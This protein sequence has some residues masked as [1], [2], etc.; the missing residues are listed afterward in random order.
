[1]ARLTVLSD[2]DFT[3]FKALDGPKWM[4]KRQYRTRQRPSYYAALDRHVDML[5]GFGFDNPLDGETLRQLLAVV[6]SKDRTFGP[7]FRDQ[8]AQDLEAEDGWKRLWSVCA[9]RVVEKYLEQREEP[10]PEGPGFF[11]PD[12]LV[13]SISQLIELSVSAGELSAEEGK[14]AGEDFLVPPGNPELVEDA[15]A[16][17]EELLATD[18]NF[19]AAAEGDAGR[20]IAEAERELE[21]SKSA[22]LR[23]RM[24]ELRSIAEAE[25][26][27]LLREKE[28]LAAAIVRKYKASRSEIAELVLDKLGDNP[29]TGHSTHLLPLAED[30][31]LETVRVRLDQLKGHYL[32]LEVAHWLVFTS[33]ASDGG[34][35][36]F[37]GELRYYDVAAQREGGAAEI[38]ARQRRAAVEVR[39]QKGIQWAEVDGR[40]LTEIRRMRS[41]FGRALDVQTQPAIPVIL[42]SLEG[43]AATLDRHTLLVLRI[44]ET[45]LRDEFIDYASFTAAEFAKPKVEGSEAD[46]MR[47]TVRQVKLSGQH[48]L[49][50]TDA[51]RLIANEGQRMAT[52]EFKA[53]FRQDLKGPTH[54]SSVKLSLAPDQATVM[55]SYGGDSKMSRR[56]HDEIVKRLRVALDRGVEEPAELDGIVKQIVDRARETGEVETVDILA[57]ADGGQIEAISDDEE[58]PQPATVDGDGAAPEGTVEPVKVDSGQS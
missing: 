10:A 36:R 32:R 13:S 2:A 51:C 43:D 44:L 50:S 27:P 57:P 17:L 45:G 12:A 48:I 46:P 55:T 49:S 22:L 21:I 16:A 58:V 54:L 34:K 39:L 52:V 1:M 9:G 5:A 29:E 24:R 6:V 35:A 47:P 19:A 14:T 26:L 28:A 53:R 42:P 8:G 4:R 33:T 37:E 56:L 23:L 41:A 40:N 25:E 20:E 31:D 15:R 7:F 18:I 3:W 38:A 11:L 30:P